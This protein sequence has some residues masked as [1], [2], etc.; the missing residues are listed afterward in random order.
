[1]TTKLKQLD[2]PRSPRPY[3]VGFCLLLVTLLCLPACSKRSFTN[4]NDVLRAER[5]ELQNA[6]AELN[7]KLGLREGELRALREQ[8]DG[9][10]QPIEGVEPPRLAGLVLG[11]YSGAI[12]TD[13][14]G[15]YD[16]LRVYARPVDQDG[17]QVTAAGKASVRLIATPD[18][19]EPVTLLDRQYSAEQFHKAYRSGVTGTHYTLK[20]ELPADPPTKATLLV[21][22]TD[23]VTGRPFAAQK[24][25]VLVRGAQ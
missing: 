25:I 4:E 5:L 24:E 8:A 7:A 19:G 15:V 6:V 9:T 20:A 3:G 11:M 13:G 17:R 22:L 10:A 14:D 12:D 18:T 21:T 1:M 2:V 16:A 23:A